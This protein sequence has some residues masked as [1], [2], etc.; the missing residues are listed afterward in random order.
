MSQQN[1]T[2]NSTKSPLE[3]IPLESIIKVIMPDDILNK[4]KYLCRAI[5]AVEWSGILLYTVK[6]TIKDPSKMVITLKDIIVMDKGTHTLTEFNFNE[7]IR[8]TSEYMDRHI[9]YTN[10][11]EEAIEW[12]IGLI[13]SHNTMKVYFS[14][15]DKAELVE[16]TQGHNFYLS[17]IVNNYMDMVAKVA[18]RAA[19][20]G[21]VNLDYVALDENGEEYVM[22]NKDFTVKKEKMYVYD[23]DIKS[24]QR[25]IKVD[26]WFAKNVEEVIEIADKPKFVPQ[27]MKNQVVKAKQTTAQGIHPISKLPIQENSFGPEDLDEPLT[28][29]P[30]DVELFIMTLLLQGSIDESCEDLEDVL[31]FLET[32]TD[33]FTPQELSSKVLENYGK[34][35]EIMFEDD[36]ESPDFFCKITRY[37]INILEEHEADFRYLSATIMQIKSM[38]NKFEQ[39]EHTTAG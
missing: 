17:L 33:S 23:C 25:N 3:I 30:G 34:Y 18:F 15:T 4:I 39:Y 12:K 38:L 8:D 19:V 16:N 32:F 28:A 21:K 37:V 10:E 26:K 36:S 24:K 14:P 2:N 1:L 31:M 5:S 29:E 11:F 6:G 7:K 20:E 13:H 27:P 22:E 35:Y 9:D